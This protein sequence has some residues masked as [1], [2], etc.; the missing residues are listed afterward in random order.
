MNAYRWPR[1]KRDREW[2][3]SQQHLVIWLAGLP[4]PIGVFASN[5]QRGRHVLDAARL[6]GLRVPE[7]LAVIGV[8]NDEMLCEVP[9]PSLSSVALNLERIGFEGA[10]LLD[11][12]MAG[13]SVPAEPIL[14]EP[15]GVIA[16]GSTD[17]LAIDDQLVVDAVRYIRSNV[18]RPI[19]VGDVLQQVAVSR[20]T[21]EVRFQQALGSTPHAEIQRVRLDRVKQLLVQTDWP[22]KKIAAQCGFTYAENLHGVFQKQLQ[23]TPKQYREQ[24]RRGMRRAGS[25]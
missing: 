9:T 2:P 25:G 22:L 20:K 14:V 21:L 10:Q 19:Q 3:Q 18:H 7:D 6:A 11:R 4:R 1:R 24:H 12:L 16:R 17:V 5:D 23:M 13:Q 8:D 15:H